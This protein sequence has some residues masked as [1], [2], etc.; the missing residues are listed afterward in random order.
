MGLEPFPVRR[1][2]HTMHEEFVLPLEMKWTWR[3]ACVCVCVCACAV[4]CPRCS[5]LCC[6]AIR[7]ASLVSVVLFIVRSS[8]LDCNHR[9]AGCVSVVW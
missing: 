8:V 6:V 4:V 7:V 5:A 9:V 1:N 3:C 2:V